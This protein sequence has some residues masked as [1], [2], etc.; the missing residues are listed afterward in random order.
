[1]P[2]PKSILDDVNARLTIKQAGYKS[3][4]E[5]LPPEAQAEC[6]NVRAA[7]RRGELG[8]R[9]AVARALIAAASSRGWPIAKEKQ[10]TQWLDREGS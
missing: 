10:V 9:S 7:F 4:Y 5:R 8:P 2:K 6:D 1:M 3:W